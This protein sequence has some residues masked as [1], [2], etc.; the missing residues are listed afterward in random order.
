MKAILFLLFIAV[1]MLGMAQ[2]PPK[3]KRTEI[4]VNNQ[5]STVKAMIRLKGKNIVP[6]NKF[7][8]YWYNSDKIEKNVGGYYGKLLDGKYFVFDK[9]KNLITQGAFKKG[10]KKGEWKTWNKK[11]GLKQ[12]ENMKNGLRHG[13]LVTI[14]E[15]GKIITTTTYCKGLKHGKYSQ[16]SPDSTIIKKFKKDK[17]VVCEPK[18]KSTDVKDEKSPKEKKEKI[19]KEK[20]EK[21]KDKSDDKEGVEKKE[22]KPKVKKEK[23]KE[24]DNNT[25]S[26]TE[27]DH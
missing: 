23:T 10:L 12:I 18:L 25:K 22:K 27:I 2:R 8:Y 5:D 4:V 6:D 1:T 9:A 26:N 16:V 15:T 19:K 13:K 20:P 3:L 7:V 17:E 24:S 14:D 21:N 11:G